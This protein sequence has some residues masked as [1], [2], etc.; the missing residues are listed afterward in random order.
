LPVKEGR[1]VRGTWQQI[2]L[3]EF[4]GPKTRKVIVKVTGD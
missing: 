2:F 1:M 4:D 3:A